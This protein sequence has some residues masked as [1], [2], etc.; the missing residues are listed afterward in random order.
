MNPVK[1]IGGVFD[2]SEVCQS[3]LINDDLIYEDR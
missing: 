1:F 3:E 2:S